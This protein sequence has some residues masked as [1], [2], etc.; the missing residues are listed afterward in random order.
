M[1]ET[2]SAKLVELLKKSLFDYRNNLILISPQLLAT[3][4]LF[5]L[6]YARKPLP[7]VTASRSIASGLIGLVS[8][9]SLIIDFLVLV[10]QASM[11]RKVILTGKTRLRDGLKGIRQFFWAVFVILIGM[12]MVGMVFVIPVL[13]V[14]FVYF[15]LHAHEGLQAVLEFI[16]GWGSFFINPPLD[17]ILYL[18]LAPAILANLEMTTSISSGLSAAK[19]NVTC[20][21]TLMGFMFASEVVTFG[22]G[23][24]N[25]LVTAHS[26]S[27]PM[28]TLEGVTAI[29][30]TLPG[31]LLVPL[32]M[33]LGFRIYS[34][35]NASQVAKAQ[36]FTGSPETE[37]TKVCRCCGGRMPS[38]A[39]YCP[40]CGTPE[41]QETR[42]CRCCGGRTPLNARYCPNCGTNV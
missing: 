28:Y 17:A 42:V 24:L 10:V 34:E 15:S 19:K 23:E 9:F 29:L 11:T 27:L 16:F 13:I 37:V 1:H 38:T 35:S 5:L 2:A 32:C 33:L 20:F 4:I 7:T 30:G 26:A 25:H 39:R 3:V 22:L 31:A 40:N 6:S 41:T 18:S 36:T 21:I 14:G 12:T 8:I